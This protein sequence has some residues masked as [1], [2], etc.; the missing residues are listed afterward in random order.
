MNVLVCWCGNQPT[1]ELA[2]QR[3]CAW[4]APRNKLLI[5]HDGIHSSTDIFWT[6]SKQNRPKKLLNANFRTCAPSVPTLV[7]TVGLGC[8]RHLNNHTLSVIT[9]RASGI[10]FPRGITSNIR[11][12]RHI[13]VSGRRVVDDMRR[14]EGKFPY[15]WTVSPLIKKAS[16][17]PTSR[18]HTRDAH[19]YK[20]KEFSKIRAPLC[21]VIVSSYCELTLDKLPTIWMWLGRLSSRE[22]IRRITNRHACNAYVASVRKNC[23]EGCFTKRT[24]ALP[25]PPIELSMMALVSNSSIA[26]LPS[27]TTPTYL[28]RSECQSVV[29]S[30]RNWN[31]K[32]KKRAM[33]TTQS[34]Q[35]SRNASGL[36]SS[37]KFA[38]TFDMIW[39]CGVRGVYSLVPD[40]RHHRNQMLR[41]RTPVAWEEK[42]MSRKEHPGGWWDMQ[43]LQQAN[44][45]GSQRTS[46]S[47]VGIILL[48]FSSRPW[49]FL[50]EPVAISSK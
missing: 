22:L 35:T 20:H 5:S 8:S 33:L 38:V 14:N 29:D 19:G 48:P 45:P 44:N 27:P 43:R 2:R 25:R 24:L 7:D 12:K 11:A 10:L 50:S 28:K 23:I 17:S 15:D 39:T 34:R 13:M 18:N 46:Y 30:W 31:Q 21:L 36:R 3:L 41:P 26:F 6:P 32:S 37:V 1:L 49:R 16:F 9:R 4:R 47:T 40:H 42:N